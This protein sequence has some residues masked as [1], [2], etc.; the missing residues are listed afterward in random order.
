[1]L[2]LHIDEKINIVE[3][4]IS[5]QPY[6][7]EVIFFGLVFISFIGDL[8]GEVSGHAGALYWILMTPLFFLCSI[9]ISKVQALS[10]GETVE[11]NIR[12]SLALWGSAFI[13]ILLIL[14]LWHAEA[15]EADTVGLIIHVVIAHTLFVSGTVLGVRFFLMGLF[16]FMMAWLTI[17]LE[18]LVGMVFLLA[19]PFTLLRL[20][21]KRNA[22]VD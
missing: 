22:R 17:A 12:F 18:G 21:I 11:N 4:T 2:A 14:Y 9:I 13:A 16:L 19:I 1:M 5:N 3:E 15:I 8:M 7:N 10:S 6:I 20:Y